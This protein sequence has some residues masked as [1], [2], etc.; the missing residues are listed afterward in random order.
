M[1]IEITAVN[2]Q[3]GEFDLHFPL[4]AVG[5]PLLGLFPTFVEMVTEVVP[6]F[7]G[8][9]AHAQRQM[10]VEGLGTVR[11]TNVQSMVDNVLRRL[12]DI[13]RL[14]PNIPGIGMSRLNIIDHGT[15]AGIKIGTDIV[16]HRNFAT[17][18]RRLGRL[19]DRFDAKGFI[20]IQA[21][22][23]G[24]NPKDAGQVTMLVALARFMRV[25]V[26]AGTGFHHPILRVNTGDYV[27]ANPDGSLSPDVGRP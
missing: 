26:Y 19:K 22:D 23:A 21:C 11:M 17:Y 1:G 14:A 8:P 10:S 13:Q 15:S 25:P 27:R 16:N 5:I 3:L 18:F 7:A 12:A 6:P 9:L 24:G 2:A 20:H 4:T